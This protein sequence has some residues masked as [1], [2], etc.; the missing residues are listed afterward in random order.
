MPL[1]IPGELMMKP[2]YG[3][4]T[5]V[6]GRIIISRAFQKTLGELAMSRF[7][8][9]T[10][11][12]LNQTDLADK[13]WDALIRAYIFFVGLPF[14]LNYAGDS[15]MVN[16]NLRPFFEQWETA[17][18]YFN[19]RTYKRGQQVKNGDWSAYRDTVLSKTGYSKPLYDMFNPRQDLRSV[20]RY[21]SARLLEMQDAGGLNEA[22]LCKL[23]SQY[24]VDTAS[25]ANFFLMQA[26][27][28]P[29]VSV[30]IGMDVII[31]FSNIQLMLIYRKAMS[32]KAASTDVPAW[33]KSQSARI[34]S[35]TGFS[36]KVYFDTKGKL[37][38]NIPY[39][40]ERPALVDLNTYGLKLSL[41]LGYP[42]PSEQAFYEHWSMPPIPPP[43]MVLIM[44]EPWGV[45]SEP[46]EMFLLM[47]EPW[48]VQPIEPPEMTLLMSEPWSPSEPP[49]M[50]LKFT[51][52]WGT[53]IPEFTQ[54]FIEHWTS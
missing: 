41:H 2:F 15:I 38:V 21:K 45:P 39:S 18:T 46:P 27:S 51:E 33:L 26:E 16:D 17:K 12:I 53:L 47:L 6:N 42:P 32:A 3:L 25:P 35:D 30:F 37:S 24:L 31:I 19:L 14:I 23:P 40:A 8:S 29:L 48:S 54:R 43:E 34:T 9:Y 1:T 28:V 20:E 44:T 49:A 11:S 5:A 52:H 50:A 4:K 36:S 10:G 13:M 7:I 22:Q